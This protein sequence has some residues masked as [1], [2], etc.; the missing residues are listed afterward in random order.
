MYFWGQHSLQ[1]FLQ[2]LS[3]HC[4]NATLVQMSLW[5]SLQFDIVSTQGIGDAAEIEKTE[6]SQ[7]HFEMHGSLIY[8]W[9]SVNGENRMITNVTLKWYSFNTRNMWCGW[10]CENRMITNVT[11]KFMAIWYSFNTR[12]MWC[13]GNLENRMITNVTLKFMAVWYS[14]NTRNRRC[15]ENC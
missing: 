9:C 15:S 8:R 4:Q 6:W 13:G 12:N 10:N 1:Y 11:L 3:L 14:F 2:W 5:N 7:S